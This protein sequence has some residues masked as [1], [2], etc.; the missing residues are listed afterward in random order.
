MKVSEIMT[1]KVDAVRDNDLVTK[2]RAI[3]RNKGFRAMPVIDKNNK[4]IGVISR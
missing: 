4:M 2:A 3:M 1:K